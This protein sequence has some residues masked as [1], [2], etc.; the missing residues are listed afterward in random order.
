MWSPWKNSP[1]VT[2]LFLLAACSDS[3][4]PVA[5]PSEATLDARL[6]GTW[7]AQDRDSSDAGRIRVVPFDEH[8]AVAELLILEKFDDVY[9]LEADLFRVLVVD[10][11]GLTWISATDLSDPDWASQAKQDP[12][13]WIIARLDFEDD[14]SVLFREISNSVDLGDIET[15][16]E[17]RAILRERRDDPDFLYDDGVRFVQYDADHDLTQYP[18]REIRF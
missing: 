18:A 2:L 11:D 6:F 4:V 14:G 3:P 16:E 10:I 8:Q 1:A 17:L 9:E 5:H 15:V 13:S 7:V 12:L